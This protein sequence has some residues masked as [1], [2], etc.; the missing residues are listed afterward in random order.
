MRNSIEL[1]LFFLMVVSLATPTTANALAIST[2]E[3]L[4]KV[5]NAAEH[6]SECVSYLELVYK[7][8]KIAARMNESRPKQIVGSCGPDKG[9]D[10]V[11]LTIALR[12]AWQEYA[13]EFPDRLDG[14]A[15]EEVLL[16]YE[17]RWPCEE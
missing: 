8:I 3:D 5:C 6:F 11:P 13:E 15:V 16:A 7:T 17:R 12:L 4:Q 10:T 9:I 2:G 1:R 14:Q